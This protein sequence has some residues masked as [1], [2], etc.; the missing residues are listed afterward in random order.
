MIHEPHRQ[1]GGEQWH[2]V[3]DWVRAETE[4]KRLENEAS[5]QAI[6]IAKD[7]ARRHD[8]P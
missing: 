8:E 3:E 5:M 1:R 2:A 7:W 4:L 6:T